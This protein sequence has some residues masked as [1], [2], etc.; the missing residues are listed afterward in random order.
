[1]TGEW[2]GMLEGTIANRE[3][4][5]RVPRAAQSSNRPDLLNE[6]RMVFIF[7]AQNDRTHRLPPETG[8]AS[9][10]SVRRIQCIETATLGGSSVQ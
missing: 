7:K 3:N 8:A 4:A 6:L 9:E 10:C 5:V 2:I 1:M